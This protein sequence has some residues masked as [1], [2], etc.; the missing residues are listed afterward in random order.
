VP[1][2]MTAAPADHLLTGMRLHCGTHF[3]VRNR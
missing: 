2:V 3:S 1:D